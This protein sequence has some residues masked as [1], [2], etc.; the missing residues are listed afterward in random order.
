MKPTVQYFPVVQFIIL[1]YKWF[2]PLHL[3]DEVVKCNHLER[4]RLTYLL[5][6]HFY[7]IFYYVVQDS[8]DFWVWMGEHLKLEYT[9]KILTEFLLLTKFF[10]VIIICGLNNQ[11]W[12]FTEEPAQ[13]FSLHVM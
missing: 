4:R 3:V 12:T 2:L 8:Y 11:V 9:N 7:S 13:Y 1:L 5:T 10:F 6:V